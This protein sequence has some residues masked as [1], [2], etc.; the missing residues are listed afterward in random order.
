MSEPAEHPTRASGGNPSA[1][2]RRRTPKWAMPRTPPEPST[3]ANRGRE[4]APGGL[5]GSIS[6]TGAVATPVSWDGAVREEIQL[7]PFALRLPPRTV[8]PLPTGVV[9]YLQVEGS[10][11]G[12]VVEMSQMRQLMA[13]GVDQARVL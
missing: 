6:G 12:T 4:S 5:R 11:A 8:D 13:E 1:I 3:R 2:N 9:Q 7:D 10:E